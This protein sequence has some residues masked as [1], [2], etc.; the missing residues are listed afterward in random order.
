MSI[1]KFGFKYN[2]LQFELIY[3]TIETSK[4]RD[5]ASSGTNNYIKFNLN[6]INL[7]LL[8]ITLSRAAIFKP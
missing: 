8:I 1:L 4:P 5:I 2:T 7:L 6:P 3:Y